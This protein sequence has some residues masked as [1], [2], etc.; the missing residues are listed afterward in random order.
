MT[1]FLLILACGSPAHLQYDHGN[2]YEAAMKMQSQLDR[3][4]AINEVY[5]LSGAEAAG[6][7]SQAEKATATEEEKLETAKKEE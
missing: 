7:R 6:I 4:S 1:T 2:A 5:P 3:A